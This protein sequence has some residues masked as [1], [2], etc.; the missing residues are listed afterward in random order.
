MLLCISVNRVEE[1]ENKFKKI[2]NHTVPKIPDVVV[3][4]TESTKQKYVSPSVLWCSIVLSQFLKPS[5]FVQT[6]LYISDKNCVFV[7][8][9]PART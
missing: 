3:V 4:I 7:H 6:G 1:K 8:D 2:I 5:S 9:T